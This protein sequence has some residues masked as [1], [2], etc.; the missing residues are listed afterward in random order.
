VEELEKGQFKLYSSRSI[1]GGT[2]LGGPLAA[3]YMIGENFKTQGRKREGTISLVIG[4][5]FTVILF[6]SLAFIPEGI[7][8][9]IPNQLIPLVYMGIAAGLV[10]W[11]QGSFINLHKKN[12][13]AFYSGWRTAL[14]G[15]ISILIIGI[16]FIP[17]ILL[18]T[19]ESLVKYDA[20][21]SVFVK[22]ENEAL[23]FYEQLETAESSTII[24]E[25]ESIAI[26]K[27]NENIAIVSRILEIPDLDLE[28]I[29]QSE[30]LLSYSELR[31]K[32]V[33]LLKKA[34][35]EDSDAYFEEIRAI[36]AEIEKGL[37]KLN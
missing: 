27:W 10:E 24:K 18:N 37:I 12:G 2:F 6:S 19:N 3:G 35:E 16:V 22:N 5:V 29:K 25:L 33:I 8:E 9:N 34:F 36:H 15:F 28:L 13:L 23:A 14:V 4:I 31:L 30:I 21:V 20:E 11:K 32:S 17:I 7:V 1:W 26:P